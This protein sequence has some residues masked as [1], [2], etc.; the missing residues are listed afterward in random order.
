M[1]Y[2]DSGKQ[3]LNMDFYESYTLEGIKVLEILTRMYVKK[4]MKGRA[5]C[6]FICQ[7]FIGVLLGA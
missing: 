6:T 1:S 2:I 7:I 5:L 4:E 3:R